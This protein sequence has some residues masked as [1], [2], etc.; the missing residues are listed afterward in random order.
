MPKKPQPKAPIIEALEALTGKPV[1]EH[2]VQGCTYDLRPLGDSVDALQN[3]CADNAPRP[4]MT[5][6]GI[7]EAA[8][9]LVAGAI[10]NGNLQEV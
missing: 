9:L 10:E 4:W 3:W 2:L 7:I 6:L 8:E 1:P 5:G